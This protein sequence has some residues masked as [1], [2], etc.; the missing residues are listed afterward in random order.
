MAIGV[1]AHKAEFRAT[2]PRGNVYSPEGRLVTVTDAPTGS[3]PQSTD[4]H[5]GDFATNAPALAAADAC[6]DGQVRCFDGFFYAV[7]TVV[8]LISFSQR[9]T[10]YPNTRSPAGL[11]L[12]ILLNTATVLGWLL[13]S[14][15]AL[16]FTRFARNL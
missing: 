8:P 15:F 6:G 9:S 13:S 14:I 4:G 5:R 16:S 12:E 3:A 2:D 10:W 1:Y 7:D 11:T